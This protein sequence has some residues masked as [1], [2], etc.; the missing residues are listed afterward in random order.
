VI[1]DEQTGIDCWVLG[2]VLEHLINPWKVL[3]EIYEKSNSLTE[4]VI[5]IPNFQHWSIQ[6]K[7]LTGDLF[8]EESGLLD[9]SHLRIFT[10]K[11]FLY[12][13]KKIGFKLKSI[14]SINNGNPL[15]DYDF[16]NLIDLA[17]KKGVNRELYVAEST[18]YQYVINLQKV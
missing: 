16:K 15:Q 17:V 9:K 12:Y 1:I 3:H 4:F 2:D 10:R 8:Y 11:T 7:L 13:V 5:C 14:K 18:A 6:Y